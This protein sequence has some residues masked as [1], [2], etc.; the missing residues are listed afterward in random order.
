MKDK[1]KE[2]LKKEA[3]ARLKSKQSQKTDQRA[4]IDS[5]YPDDK[6]LDEIKLESGN[7]PADSPNVSNDT[8]CID[9]INVHFA[10]S[11]LILILFTG[12]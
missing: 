10:C 11:K 7:K 1:K 12:N 9:Y 6:L 2:K 4:A 3:E 8:V 5:N